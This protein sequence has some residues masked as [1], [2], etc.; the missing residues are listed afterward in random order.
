M[1]TKREIVKETWIDKLKKQNQT[2]LQ[3]LNKKHYS[4]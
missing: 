1:A 4:L 2:K 3:S